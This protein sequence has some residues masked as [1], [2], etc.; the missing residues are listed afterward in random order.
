MTCRSS[1]TLRARN[2]PFLPVRF[3]MKRA[4][5]ILMAAAA[6]VLAACDGS[7]KSV[8]CTATDTHSWCKLFAHH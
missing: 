2:P 1:V 4:T 7:G 6:F 5:I 8:G 3:M